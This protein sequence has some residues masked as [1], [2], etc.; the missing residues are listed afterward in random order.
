MRVGFSIAPT[1]VVGKRHLFAV[2]HDVGRI[3]TVRVHLVVVA[4]KQIK[5]MLLRHARRAAS[6]AAPFAKAARGIA[7][8]FQKRAD[9]GFVCSQR[10][11][12]P[13]GPHRRVAAVLA[14][15]KAAPRRRTDGRP[16]QGRRE[17][18]AFGCHLIEPWRL[19]M[20]IAHAGELKVAQLVGHDVDDI[21]PAGLLGVGRR[22]MCQ[23][24]HHGQGRHHPPPHDSATVSL[25]SITSSCFHHHPSPR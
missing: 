18:H 21:R 15:K 3:V 2:P 11:A 12:P 13:V 19:Q 7:R 20:R 6:P 14:G 17:P 25:T 4:K 1:P 9:R 16:S 22:Q 8:R 23:R 10:R 5:A 24:A